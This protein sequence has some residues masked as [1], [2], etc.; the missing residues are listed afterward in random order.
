MRAPTGL[1]TTIQLDYMNI[2][3]SIE[4]EIPSQQMSAQRNKTESGIRSDN[5]IAIQDDAEEDVFL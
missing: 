4:E 5:E 2:A 1:A 3:D